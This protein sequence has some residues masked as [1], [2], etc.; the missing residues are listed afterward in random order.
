M[1]MGRRYPSMYGEVNERH[2]EVAD[3]A[4]TVTGFQCELRLEEILHTLGAPRR[5]GG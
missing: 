1:D 2:L 3:E 5:V 4:A